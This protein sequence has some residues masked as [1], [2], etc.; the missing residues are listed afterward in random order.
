MPEH[1]HKTVK[2]NKAIK[3]FYFHLIFGMYL[4]VRIYAK[5]KTKHVSEK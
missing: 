5:I 1:S 3:T 2:R 4:F